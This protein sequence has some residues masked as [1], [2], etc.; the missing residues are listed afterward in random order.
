VSKGT[1]GFQVKGSVI[2]AKT[3]TPQTGQPETEAIAETF[4]VTNLP[5]GPHSTVTTQTGFK[6][7]ANYQTVELRATVQIPCAPGLEA[8][9]LEYAGNVASEYLDKHHGDAANALAALSQ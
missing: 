9:A 3:V 4:D 7:S 2:V 8:E 1:G 5:E 6:I